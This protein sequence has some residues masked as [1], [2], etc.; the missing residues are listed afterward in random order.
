MKDWIEN[1]W[2][3]MFLY[4]P[5]LMAFGAA[6][7]FAMTNEPNL[8]LAP[9]ITLILFM[10]LFI[11]KIPQLIRGALLILF[12]FYYAAA[13]T[14]IINTPQIKHNLHDI[15][16]LG[17]VEN[18]DY[19]YDKNK[20]TLSVNANDIGAGDGYAKVKVSLSPD[21]PTP[22]IGDTVQIN[23]GI[24]KPKPAV[25]PDTFDYARWSYFNNLTATGYADEIKIIKQNH[26]NNINNMRQYLHT[27]SNSFLSD[28]LILGY[29]SAISQDV[30]DTWAATGVGH[31]WSISGF[32]MTLVGGWIFALF[33]LIFRS[34]PYITRRIPAKIPAIICSWFGLLFYLFLSD[35]DVATIRAFLMT[36][37]IFLAFIFGRN[38]ISMRNIALA[39]CAIFLINPHYVMQAGFQLSFAAVFGLVW[40]YTDIKPKM[41]RNKLLKVLYISVL[42]SLV[43]TIFTAPFVAMH[44]GKFPL[45]SL[46]GNLIFLPIFSVALMPLILIGTL[47]ATFGFTAPNDLAHTIYDYAYQIAIWISDLPYATISV[48]H[49]SNT[50][51]ILFIIGFMCLIL[52]KPIKIKVNYILFFVFMTLGILCVY[53][54]PK[55]IFYTTYDNELIGI[56]DTD[57]KLKFNK[58]RASNHYFTFDTWKQMNNEETQTKNIR[59]KHDNGV[60]RHDNIVYIQKFVPLMKNISQLC[61]DDSV[62][63]IVSYFD[64]NS[65]KC[66]N[67]ILRGG[68][69][70]YPNNSVKLTPSKRKWH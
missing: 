58:S 20:L 19:T 29:K 49:I 24:Y 43:A 35:I 8:F 70:I 41:P 26:A 37:L 46:I 30:K 60:Y 31:I 32:H 62:E 13:F 59:L 54:T 40:L 9:P 3:N 7:Y 25:A 50:S 47:T 69:V 66:D 52:I 27:K 34:I 56:L 53:M 15:E 45:Y 64:I 5:F 12:G 42:T 63:Y 36:S 57:G 48:P 2:Q 4:A 18:I 23:G 51:A 33:Y 6:V 65:K 38:A 28:T 16:I 14:N 17:T 61:N 22:N 44:F 21:T 67:K 11:K 39:F 55:P 1:Q 10:G 68:F